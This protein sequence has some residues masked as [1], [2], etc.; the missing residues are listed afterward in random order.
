M[1]YWSPYWNVP[2]FTFPLGSGFI[3][4]VVVRQA[5][6][7][8]T[9]TSG[10]YTNPRVPTSIIRSSLKSRTAQYKTSAFISLSRICSINFTEEKK[11]FVKRNAELTAQRAKN[12]TILSI[13]SFD[14]T[15]EP[16]PLNSLNV[17][18]H[19]QYFHGIH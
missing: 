19:S 2:V 3:L 9:P 12:R 1:Q 18:F 15:S 14:R 4:F 11:R 7:N 13:R 17:Q 8:V 6:T 16:E 10:V 5:A